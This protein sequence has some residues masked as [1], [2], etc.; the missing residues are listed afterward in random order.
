MKRLRH[1]IRTIREPFGTAGVIGPLKHIAETGG[2]NPPH[3]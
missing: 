3:R 2:S 1:P